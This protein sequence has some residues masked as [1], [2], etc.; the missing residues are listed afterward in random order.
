MGVGMFAPCHCITLISRSCHGLRRCILLAL[1]SADHVV[2]SAAE[3]FLP[4]LSF[5][6]SKIENSLLRSKGKV[7]AV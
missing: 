7:F 6:H 4:G 3:W 2:C 5:N 1:F